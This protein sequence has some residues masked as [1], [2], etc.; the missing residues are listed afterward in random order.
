MTNRIA[1]ATAV[2]ICL[3]FAR[4][5]T[6]AKGDISLV[7][8]LSLPNPQRITDVWGYSDGAGNDYAIVGDWHVGFYIV[9]ATNPGTP[10]EVTKVT[11]IVGFDVKVWDHYVYTC[12][13]GSGG[14]SRIVDIS[15]VNSP[16]I[17]PGTFRST[18]NIAISDQG[19]MYTEY[20][21]LRAYD[22]GPDP[23][24]PDSLWHANSNGHDSTPGGDRLYDFTGYDQSVKIWDVS[25]PASPSVISTIYDPALNYSHSGDASADGNYLY[26][27]DE[28]AT[29]PEP[30]IVVYDITN[31]ASPTR[32]GDL[33]EPSA[34][35]H[36]LYV[37][38]DLAF[39]AHYT[40]GFRTLDLSDPAN[41]TVA[42]TYDTSAQTGEGYDGAFGIYPYAPGGLIYVCDQPNG[43]Y[44]FSVEGFNGAPTGVGSTAPVAARLEQNFPNPFNPST[45]IAYSLD[46]SGPVTLSVFDVTG[47]RVRTLVDA[48]RPSGRHQVEWN[49]TDDRGRAVASG[50][51]YCRLDASGGELTRKMVLLK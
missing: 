25:N 40:A 2:F 35:I 16:I 13:G 26:V 9:D 50:V 36:N 14:L 44:I 45:T 43:L 38:G 31:L 18:H 11:G 6:A 15:D 47:A 1:V 19:I 42:D 29:H 20:P 3:L 32:V 27:C 34:T 51:Y 30:D 39:I 7:G 46:A 21:G 49:G 22:L 10:V 8:Y 41:P 17:L 4:P 37:V 5:A 23:E 24:N 33:G 28:L 12:D 48:S